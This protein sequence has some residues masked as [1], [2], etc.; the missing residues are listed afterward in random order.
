MINPTKKGSE[1]SIFPLQFWIMEYENDDDD[2]T[3]NEYQKDERPH[4]L[5]FLFHYILVYSFIS[6]PP[7]IFFHKYIYWL[8]EIEIKK[9]Y[10]IIARMF[11]LMQERKKGMH[12]FYI[13][14][15]FLFRFFSCWLESIDRNENRMILLMPLPLMIMMLMMM[16]V[17]KK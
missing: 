16:G 15:F 7:W 3:M 8:N 11:M 4:G 2:D 13:W 10:W 17:K 5:V 14:P 12:F 1:C 6:F 9:K